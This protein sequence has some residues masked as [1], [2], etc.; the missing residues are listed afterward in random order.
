MVAARPGDDGVE[1]LLL[2]RAPASRF[3]PGYVVFPG[4]VVDGGDELLALRWFGDRAERTRACAVR[5]LAEEA[6]LALTAD[7]VR[8]L[9]PGET[10]E[11]AV[12]PSPPPPAALHDMARWLA[13]EFL[14]VRFDA[15]FYAVDA[16]PAAEAVPDEIEVD[17]AWWMGPADALRRFPLSRSLMWPTYRT[18][19]ALTACSAVDEVLR[20]EVPQEPPPESLLAPAVSP[21]WR[22]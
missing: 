17:R 10:V 12:D 5:E 14:A 8:R 19:H 15:W 13:P 22:D 11:R 9:E 3:A 16:G 6:R 7:G 4:G 20:L 18:L 2:Q 1:V 21:E